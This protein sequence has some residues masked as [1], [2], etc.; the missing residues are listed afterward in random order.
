MIVTVIVSDAEAVSPFAPSV[1][2]AV[3]VSSFIDPLLETSD[4]V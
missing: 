3:T 4:A 2:V 1:A